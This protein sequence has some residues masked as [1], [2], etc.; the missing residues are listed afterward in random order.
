MLHLDSLV[1]KSCL[2]WFLLQLL[3]N[4]A[5]FSPCFL[6]LGSFLTAAFPLKPFLMRL[7]QTVGGSTENPV[8]G[9]WSISILYYFLSKLSD[10][11]ISAVV[12]LRPAT[13]P[14]L[15][16]SICLIDCTHAEIAL[17]FIAMKRLGLFYN[18]LWL[19]TFAPFV[20]LYERSPKHGT[21]HAEAL[22]IC[23]VF[24]FSLWII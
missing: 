22:W 19:K 15:H 10:F 12:L 24:R 13:S 1:N 11:Q 9:L 20:N 3:C 5:H 6:Y 18:Y 14:V 2:Y 4:L 8:S 7:W 23:T 21:P 16:S 17:Y